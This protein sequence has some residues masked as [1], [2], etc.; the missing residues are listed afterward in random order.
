MFQFGLA[1][2][3]ACAE[4]VPVEKN[5]AVKRAI[6]DR[7]T[8]VMGCDVFIMF[9]VM[10]LSLRV[11]CIELP[12]GESRRRVWAGSQQTSCSKEPERDPHGHLT[13]DQAPAEKHAKT[14]DES[15]NGPV[16]D[17]QMKMGGIHAGTLPRISEYMVNR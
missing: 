5:I 14:R 9:E 2:V 11:T 1:M 4:T 3:I 12:G 8:Q 13:A 16:I 6:K 17:G 15:D 7:R 10:G